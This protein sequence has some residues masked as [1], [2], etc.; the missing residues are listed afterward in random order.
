M[1]NLA[2]ELPQK[3]ALRNNLERYKKRIEEYMDEHLVF[4]FNHLVFFSVQKFQSV[5]KSTKNQS[6]DLHPRM[7]SLT[8]MADFS[9]MKSE[10]E[11]EAGF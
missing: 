7:K 8:T 10:I 2:L 6:L 4:H 9:D 5:W 3:N 11:E 1:T